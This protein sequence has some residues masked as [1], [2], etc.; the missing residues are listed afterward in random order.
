VEVRM[1]AAD[2]AEATELAAKTS[3]S[4]RLAPCRTGME[5]SEI[6]TAV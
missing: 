4:S 6:R 5:K 2:P 3:G 1:A